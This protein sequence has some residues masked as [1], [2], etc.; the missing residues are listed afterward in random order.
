MYCPE[1]GSKIENDDDL[2]CG[3]CGTSLKEYREES[4]IDEQ[5]KGDFSSTGATIP[6]KDMQAIPPVKQPVSKTKTILICEV[7]AAAVLLLGIFLSLNKLF[8]PE[9]TAL[10]YWRAVQ[11]ADWSSAYSYYS[12]PDNEMLSEQMYINAHANDTKKAVYKAEKISSATK[13]DNDTYTCT[14]SYLPEGSTT[15][16]TDQ[17]YLVRDGRKFLFWSNWKVVPSDSWAENFMIYVPEGASVKL[18]GETVSLETAADSNADQNWLSTVIPYIF[19][20]KYQL[21]VSAEGMETYCTELYIDEYSSN[22]YYISL[23]PSEET[24]EQLAQQYGTD[25]KA[26]LE[27]AAAGTDFSEISSYFSSSASKDSYVQ[28]DYEDLSNLAENRR[29]LSYDI[30]DIRVTVDSFDAEDHEV[31]LYVQ[32]QLTT[33][34]TSYWSSE[35]RS[36]TDEISAYVSYI[37]ED[38]GWKLQDIPLSYYLF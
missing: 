20:G 9:T 29:L 28:S 24:K 32:M 27:N 10:K 31:Q 34:S 22:E 11:G 30:S 37:R 33:T 8:S 38:N 13:T 16:E 35:P 12:V 7:I 6:A 3:E 5:E 2:F 4:F 25:L 1:C 18:N 23:V 15:K 21:E 26:I 19:Y 17:V 14:I 36:D